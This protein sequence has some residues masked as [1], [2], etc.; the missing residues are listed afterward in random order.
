[1]ALTN[2]VFSSGVAEYENSTIAEHNYENDNGQ[3]SSGVKVCENSATVDHNY[4]NDNGQLFRRNGTSTYQDL[5]TDKIQIYQK[6]VS[7]SQIEFINGTPNEGYKALSPGVQR[8]SLQEE[9]QLG[10]ADIDEQLTTDQGETTGK[11]E[12]NHPHRRRGQKALLIIFLA[13]LFFLLSALVILLL[14]TNIGPQLDDKIMMQ[15]ELYVKF[16]RNCPGRFFFNIYVKN[17]Q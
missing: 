9:S 7:T 15:G 13:M 5:Q 2:R 16:S 14:T 8:L 4:K 11:R 17:C 12:R 1:M 10:V 3:M 6:L